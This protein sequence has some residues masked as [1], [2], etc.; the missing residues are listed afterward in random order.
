MQ[1]Q[2]S[3][4]DSLLTTGISMKAIT[5]PQVSFSSLTIASCII[6]FGG[7]TLPSATELLARAYSEVISPT[8]DVVAALN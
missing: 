1:S 5:G 3:K 8:I 2:G 4:L 7:T 6:V